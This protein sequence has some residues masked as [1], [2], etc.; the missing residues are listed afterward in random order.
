MPRYEFKYYVHNNF[1]DEL[2]RDILPYLEYDPHLVKQEKKEY[3]VRSTYLDSPTL[4]TYD[5]KMSGVRDRLKFRIRGYDIITQESVGFIEIKRKTGDYISKDRAT[6]RYKDID[7]FFNTQNYDLLYASVSTRPYV[8]K[9]AA[10]FLYYYFA[11]RLKPV[12]AINYDREAFQCRFGTDLRITFD[13]N[14]RAFPTNSLSQPHQIENMFYPLPD[15]FVLEIKFFGTI[16]NWLK[17]ILLKYD[18]PRISASK[19][20]M[21]MDAINDHF[22]SFGQNYDRKP[23]IN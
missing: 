23:S 9:C 18:L 12:V 21:S 10:N 1:L 16:P 7:G 3:L 5:E 6:I 11:H 14:I 8:E 17:P 19:Y 15:M 13:K 20:I 2:R 22:Y 4:M